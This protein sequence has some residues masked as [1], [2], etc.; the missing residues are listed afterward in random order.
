MPDGEPD[1]SWKNKDTLI[2]IA[3]EMGELKGEVK[4]L[5][6]GFTNHLKHHFRLNMAL[7]AGVIGLAIT[8]LYFFLPLML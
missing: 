8:G 2:W 3:H 6:T 5:N 7:L 1:K 4:V